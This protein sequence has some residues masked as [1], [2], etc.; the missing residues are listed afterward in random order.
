MEFA[1]EVGSVPG[2]VSRPSTSP[3]FVDAT[4]DFFAGKYENFLRNRA[5]DKSLKVLSA[6]DDH[7]LKDI[8]IDRGAIM[9][10]AF[11]TSRNIYINRS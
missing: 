4:V 5:Y 8:G 1:R 10:T 11:K 3:S 9:A 6:L 7:I 2:N